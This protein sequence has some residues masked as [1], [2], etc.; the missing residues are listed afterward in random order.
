[1]APNSIRVARPPDE[2]RLRAMQAASLRALG[3]SYY[4]RE[5]MNA[6]IDQL[7]TMD[8]SLL[9]GGR[10]FVA[11][12]CDEFIASGGWSTSAPGY[13]A[14]HP[15]RAG[16]D[17]GHPIVRSVFV[18]PLFAGLGIGRKLMER[19]EADIAAAGY[20]EVQVKATLPGVPFYERLGFAAADPDPIHLPGGLTFPCVRMR[21]SL[22][23]GQRERRAA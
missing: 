11:E 2:A 14:H 19:V 21:K 8:G 10:Y 3:R 22:E 4:S 7:G 5:L 6:F 1:M 16:W 15:D 17:P 23:A 9:H 12:L 13:E 18:A 20:S